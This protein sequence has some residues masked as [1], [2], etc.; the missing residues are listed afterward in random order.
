MT[1][2]GP[3]DMTLLKESYHTL[4]SSI[5]TDTVVAVDVKDLVSVVAMVP[6]QPS[7][8]GKPV[9]ERFYVVEKPGLDV[10]NMGGVEDDLDD[11]ND[12]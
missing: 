12:E 11:G 1:L 7:I 4:W 9:H 2:F 5:K 6:H 3:P 10:A 8:P